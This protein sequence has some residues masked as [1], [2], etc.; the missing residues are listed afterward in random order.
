MGR[1]YRCD[2]SVEIG[3]VEC[4]CIVDVAVEKARL[5]HKVRYLGALGGQG[6]A[7]LTLLI[8]TFTAVS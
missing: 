7:D 1:D 3:S 2:C 5:F 6:I 8:M 4:G